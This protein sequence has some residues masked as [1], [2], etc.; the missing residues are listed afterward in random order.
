MTHT[1]VTDT[2]TNVEREDRM[3]LFGKAHLFSGSLRSPEAEPPLDKP[4]QWGVNSEVGRLREV[5]LC[6]PDYWAIDS[7]ANA[8]TRA[9]VDAGFDFDLEA[10]KRQH[11]E[12]AKLFEREGVIIR[13]LP[14]LPSQISQT[15]TRNSSF[16]T[17]WGVVVTQM[18]AEVRRGEYLAI[19]DYC[20]RRNIP[21]W[22]KVTAGTLE[23]GDVHVAKP[24]KLLIGYSQG[25]TTKDGAMQ[26]LN[27]FAEKGWDGRLIQID[28][29]FLHLDLLFCMVD[30]DTAILCRDGLS[31]SQIDEIVHFLE[32]KHVIYATYKQAMRLL[33]NVLALGNRKVIMHQDAD[34]VDLV[35]QLKEFRYEALEVDLSSFTS[36]GGG[37]HCLAMSYRRDYLGGSRAQHG[38]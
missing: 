34:N 35:R 11:R 24:G 2:D 3:P 10:A 37:P 38:I 15:Y 30:A 4:V 6:K 32:L 1:G 25:R 20:Q 22:N 16:M 12:F 23:G 14:E 9:A 13:W 19:V 31:N 36:D 33:C 27:W 21:I 29:H 8:V 7:N 28:P 5:L 18:Q 26:V 17:P